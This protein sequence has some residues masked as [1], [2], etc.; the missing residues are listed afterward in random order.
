MIEGEVQPIPA[1]FK[2][3]VADVGWICLAKSCP[4]CSAWEGWA[5]EANGAHATSRAARNFF[6]VSWPW[7]L[8]CW[9]AQR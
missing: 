8:V 7:G 5:S 1:G 4:C 9:L 3:C 6:M 2:I